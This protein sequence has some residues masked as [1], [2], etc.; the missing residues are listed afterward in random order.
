MEPFVAQACLLVRHNVPAKASLPNMW[1]QT[2]DAPAQSSCCHHGL[3]GVSS[4]GQSRHCAALW[5]KMGADAAGARSLIL[6]H[7]CIP[8]AASTAQQGLLRPSQSISWT[9]FYLYPPNG[10]FAVP[11][12]PMWLCCPSPWCYTNRDA[13]TLPNCD[14]L[15][16]AQHRASSEMD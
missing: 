9:R 5:H 1:S 13:L 11:R 3:A 8:P 4:R 7:L 15:R 2:E 12:V 10:V 6:P 14:Q 16:I